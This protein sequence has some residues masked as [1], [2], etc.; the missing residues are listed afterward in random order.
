MS[1]IEV[2]DEV[3]LCLIGKLNTQSSFNPEALKQTMQNIWRPSQGLVITNLDVHLFAFQFFPIGDK[4][5]V[6]GG[7][8]WAFEGHILLL[9]NLDVNEQPFKTF[10]EYLGNKIGKFVEVDPFD[11]FIPSKALERRVDYDLD[12]PLRCRLML[13]MN[14]EPTWFKMRHVHR[15][16]VH[17]DP[18]IAETEL[19]YERGSEHLLSRKR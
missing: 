12:Q 1:L 19:Q 4:D 10:A 7:G 9:K 5:F 6:L 2:E 8:P 11:L 3:S 18:N 16:C 17:Y 13:K 15:R 14:G